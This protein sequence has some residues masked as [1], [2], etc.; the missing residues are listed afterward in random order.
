MR[1]ETKRR[2]LEVA[3][4]LRIGSGFIRVTFAGEAL[5]DFVSCSF[6]DHVK[7]IFTNGAGNEVSRDYTP[8][9]FDRDA[10]TLSIELALHGDGEATAWARQVVQGQRVIVAGPRGSMIIP[11][12]FD[13]HLLAGDATAL[14]AIQRRLEELPPTTQAIVLVTGDAGMCPNLNSRARLETM[15]LNGGDELVAALQGLTL[16]LGE[17]FAWCAGEASLMSR[18]RAVLAHEKGM[19]KEAMRVAAYWKRGA[20]NHHENLE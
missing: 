4:T 7:F 18:L 6:D 14:P 17:G 3:Q 8:R 9:H 19:T 5:N 12:D 2:N 15:W 13:W 10:R 1:H 16:P 20:S 11:E